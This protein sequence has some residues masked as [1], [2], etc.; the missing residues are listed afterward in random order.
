MPLKL[1]KNDKFKLDGGNRTALTVMLGL[2]L[3]FLIFVGL[4]RSARSEEIS[5]S[6]FLIE[7]R[8]GNIENVTILDMREIRGL[9]FDSDGRTVGFT[10]ILPYFDE[11]LMTAL[12]ES[13]VMLK[14]DS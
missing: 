11:G 1:N 9:R 5:Y 7:L 13:G 14:R 6:R 4:S 8:A 10:T 12:A 2:S 3:L